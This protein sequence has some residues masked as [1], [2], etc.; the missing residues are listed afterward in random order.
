M[1]K[2]GCE[3]NRMIARGQ[4]RG[5]RRTAEGLRPDV[6]FV[7]IIVYYS[8]GMRGKARGIYV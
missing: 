5:S 1:E 7:C 8:R 4:I 6:F 3:T 2:S